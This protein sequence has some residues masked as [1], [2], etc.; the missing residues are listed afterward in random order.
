MC[1]GDCRIPGDLVLNDM[2][3][4][5]ATLLNTIYSLIPLTLLEAVEGKHVA[6]L[7]CR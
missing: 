7:L 6:L 5:I 3:N 4:S 2:M 1:E